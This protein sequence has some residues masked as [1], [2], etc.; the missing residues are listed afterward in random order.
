[1]KLHTE[2]DIG[3]GKGVSLT[4]KIKPM[5][6]SIGKWSKPIAKLLGANRICA[7]MGE[8]DGKKAII[9]VPSFTDKGQLCKLNKRGIWQ[10]SFSMNMQEELMPYIGKAYGIKIAEVQEGY[11]GVV[12]A[13]V[14]LDEENE[15]KKVEVKPKEAEEQTDEKQNVLSPTLQVAKAVADLQKAFDTK[16]RADADFKKAVLDILGRLETN[17]KRTQQAICALKEEWK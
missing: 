16:C 6:N 2:W 13:F 3:D 17:Q 8:V 9:F 10:Y 15:I 7:V 12:E 11:V 4:G 14:I 1:M 5:A